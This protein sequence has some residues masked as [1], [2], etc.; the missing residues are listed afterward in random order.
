[1]GSSSS[2][3]LKQRRRRRQRERQKSKKSRLAKQQLCMCI[4]LSLHI[5]LLSLHVYD[6]KMPNFTFCGEREHK[7]TAV[8]LPE[9]LFCQ[10][11]SIAFL[12]FQLLISLSFQL[13]SLSSLL[14][15][16]I[17]WQFFLESNSKRLYR[18]SG[19]EKESTLVFT[20]STKREITHF[21]VVVVQ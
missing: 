3:E 15:I 6:V 18:N 14:P 8:V 17:S 11:E 13:T 12:S 21:H 1:M 4:T 19:K 5:S 7:T 20:S 10:S 2:R 16:N 9:L